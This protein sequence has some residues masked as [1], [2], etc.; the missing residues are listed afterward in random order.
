MVLRT[1]VKSKVYQISYKLVYQEPRYG[2]SDGTFEVQNTQPQLK[3]QTLHI[4][5]NMWSENSSICIAEGVMALV[6]LYSSLRLP[7]PL[8]SFAKSRDIMIA[9][10]I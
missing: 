1:K 6:F 7:I 9:C 4:T 2:M 5:Y 10:T 8:G 3:I